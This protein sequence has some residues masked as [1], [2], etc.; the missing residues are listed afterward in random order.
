MGAQARPGEDAMRMRDQIGEPLSAKRVV[1]SFHFFALHIAL[2][3][4]SSSSS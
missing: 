4:R 2:Q 3:G 1:L